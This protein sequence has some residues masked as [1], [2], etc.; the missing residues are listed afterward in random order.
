MALP[1]PALPV[2]YQLV[3]STIPVQMQRDETALFDGIDSS[4]MS[5]AKFV[6]A[7]APKDLNDG[8]VVIG[9]S[10]QIAQRVFDTVNDEATLKP[11]LDGLFAVRTLRREEIVP[12]LR[13]VF[14]LDVPAGATFRALDPDA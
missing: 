13:G 5:L 9:N 2:S 1:T 3:E 12:V 14:G 8:L 10:A 11:L 4:I 6:S 7:R